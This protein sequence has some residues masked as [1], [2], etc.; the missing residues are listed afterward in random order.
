MRRGVLLRYYGANA[1]G[2]NMGMPLVTWTDP[3]PITLHPITSEQVEA[4]SRGP[5]DQSLNICLALGGVAGGLLQNV[6]AVIGSVYTKATP[7][8][9]DLLLAMV[10]LLASGVA[11]AKFSEYRRNK[12]QHD[13]L[14]RKVLSRVVRK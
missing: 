5:D 9:N 14:K 7:P 12:P 13:A 8:M 11:L 1:S 6:F 3:D 10:C 2:I 4:L